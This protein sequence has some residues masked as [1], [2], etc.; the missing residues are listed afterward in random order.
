MDLAD[1]TE[2]KEP[3]FPN[4]RL[5]EAYKMC[6]I[7]SRADGEGPPNCKLGYA[8]ENGGRYDV[9]AQPDAVAVERLWGPSA[10]FAS[11]GM[12]RILSPSRYGQLAPVNTRLSMCTPG[13]A[14]A[15]SEIM[16]NRNVTVCPAKFGPKLMTVSM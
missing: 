6:V 16:R 9:D 2:I 12:T 8:S 11:L 4:R 3:R 13:A 14:T 10:R 1:R 7:P 15:S 5:Y